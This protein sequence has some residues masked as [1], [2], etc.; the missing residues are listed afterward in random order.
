MN[1]C[2]VCGAT[3]FMTGN[4]GQWIWVCPRRYDGYHPSYVTFTSNGTAPPPSGSESEMEG[5]GEKP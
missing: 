2:E 3:M 1:S 4:A 5:Q